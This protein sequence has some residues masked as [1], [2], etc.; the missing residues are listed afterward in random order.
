MQKIRRAAL[1]M[2]GRSEIVRMHAAQ[3]MAG[4][5]EIGCM[6]A[7]AQIVVGHAEICRATF[8]MVAC[9]E[10]QHRLTKVMQFSR[11]MGGVTENTLITV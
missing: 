5:S 3:T 7:A 10:M 8:I 9:A 1:T 2:V 11:S 4:R 6:R